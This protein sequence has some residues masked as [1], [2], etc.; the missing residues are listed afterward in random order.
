MHHEASLKTLLKKVNGKNMV[1]GKREHS[2][3]T[4]LMKTSADIFEL[5]F[6]K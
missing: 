3:L 2:A 4:P 5:T 1:Q 6:K